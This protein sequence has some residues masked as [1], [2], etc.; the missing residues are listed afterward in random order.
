MKKDQAKKQYHQDISKTKRVYLNDHNPLNFLF[1]QNRD[2]FIVEELPLERF[3]NKG[4]FLILKI[5]KVDIST[6]QLLEHISKIL[7]IPQNLIGYAGLKDKNAT[8][9]QYISI[10]L[11]KAK[12]FEK[13]NGKNIKVLQ[14][15]KHHCK[16]KIGDLKGNRFKI[17]LRNI[18]PEE[19]ETFYR[20]VSAIQKHGIPNY[21]GYQRFGIENDFKK[22][23]DV[24]RGE[25]FIKDKKVQKFLISAYQSYLF[26]DWLAERVAFSREQGSKKLIELKGDILNEG[27]ITGLMCGRKTPRAKYK[28]GEIEG[29]F[30]DMFIH[31]KGSRRDAWI[32]PEHIKNS[33]L[34]E[35]NKMVLQFTL[36]KSS[37]ATVVIESLLNKNLNP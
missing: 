28:A 24:A 12:G 37:Y 20:G 33:Y 16:I 10:P 13:L 1:R 25:L 21:F 36:P 14:T 34:K 5:K 23:K 2:D 7:H 4:N 19:L 31:E 18:L 9:T 35:E 11:N 15:F 32:K 8:T 22:A 17:V 26:N 6:W 30:D 29:Q 3:T 27:I